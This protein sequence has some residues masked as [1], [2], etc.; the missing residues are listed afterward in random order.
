MEGIDGSQGFY[1]QF[2]PT[3]A[4]QRDPKF[5]VAYE[6]HECQWNGPSWPFATAVTLTAFANVLNNY[7]EEV[8]TKA[9]YWKIFQC[10]LRSHRF[11]QIPLE[12]QPAGASHQDRVETHQPWIDENLN[13]YTGDWIAQRC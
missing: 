12:P 9:D 10:Y 6:G 13:P 11:R 3:T 8:V 1:A 4:E 2:G 7:S 5:A